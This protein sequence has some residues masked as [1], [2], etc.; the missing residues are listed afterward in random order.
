MEKKELALIEEGLKNSFKKIREELED[1][2][3]AINENTEDIGDMYDSMA[4]LESKIDKLNEKLDE[5]HMVLGKLQIPV[6]ASL[7]IKPLTINE[8][9]VFLAIYSSEKPISYAELSKQLNYSETLTSTYIDNLIEKK[10]PVIKSYVDGIAH[11]SLDK[12]FKELQAKSNLV[13]LDQKSL[14]EKY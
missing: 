5:I 12:D 3:T 11:L 7:K 4:A 2:L 8:R 14:K 13:G 9:Q 1:H 10:I 6:D